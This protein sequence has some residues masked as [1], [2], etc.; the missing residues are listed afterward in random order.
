M[1]GAALGIAIYGMF[2]AII[3][4]PA[5]KSLP[6]LL[7]ILTA[8]ALSCA[9][10]FIPVLSKVPSGFAIIICAVAA[11]VLFALVAPIKE[12]QTE[13]VSADE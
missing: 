3:V 5:K 8:I 12:E 6:T 2:I 13:E 11:S 10:K 1:L 4:P 7:C 9:F